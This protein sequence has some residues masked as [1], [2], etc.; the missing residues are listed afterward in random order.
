MYYLLYHTLDLE[1]Y[2]IANDDRVFIA[3]FVVKALVFSFFPF[4]GFLA[5]NK[6]GRFKTVLCGI[7]MMMV[8]LS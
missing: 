2:A 1:I 3:R 8:H 4:A 5:D 7:V 6:F